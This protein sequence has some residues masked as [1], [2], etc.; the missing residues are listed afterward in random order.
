MKKTALAYI[1]KITV[2]LILMF[3]LTGCKTK[4]SPEDIENL[5]QRIPDMVFLG[6]EINLPTRINKTKLLFP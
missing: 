2:F 3:L 5:K 1:G 6:D 4:V